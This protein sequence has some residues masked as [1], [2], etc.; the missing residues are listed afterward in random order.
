M[1]TDIIGREIQVDNL[2]V[3]A[4]SFY[5]TQY[6]NI[7]TVRDYFSWMD[8]YE[9]LIDILGPD[10]YKIS[11]LATSITIRE[12]KIEH[13]ATVTSPT[14]I[15]LANKISKDNKHITASNSSF[16]TNYLGGEHAM[17]KAAGFNSITHSIINPVAYPELLTIAQA[18]DLEHCA[19]AI[20]YQPTACIFPAHVDTML[21]MWRNIA[22]S[23]PTVLDLPFD[24]STKSIKGMTSI[25]LLLALTDYV[26]GH[27]LGVDDQYW[28]NWK[29]GDAVVFDNCNRMHYTANTA[30]VPRVFLRISGMINNSSDHWIINN[31]NQH[32]VKQIQL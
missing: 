17:Q 5:Q 11:K 21:T 27:V 1:I 32:L 3:S 19:V 26:P 31:I 30:W 23:D 20:Q 7:K 6:A 8:N 15:D 25:R 12:Y 2:T 9:N 16:D 22:A 18:F 24:V 29:I 4:L 10:V 28:T 14:L 13:V